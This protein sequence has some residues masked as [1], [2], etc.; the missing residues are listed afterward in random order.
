MFGR[1]VPTRV[2]VRVACW[3]AA[4]SVSCGADP[5]ATLPL[6]D[7]AAASLAGT[8]G[9]PTGGAPAAGVGGAPSPLGTPRCQPPVG[10]NGSPQTI[11]AAVSLLN[12]L[13][14]PTS[15]ACFVQSLDR[16][17]TV[18]AANSPISAQP[19]RSARSPRVFIKLERLWVSVVVDG[20]SSYLLEF[21]HLEPDGL[22]S[23]KGEVLTPLTEPLALSAPYDRIHYAG[24]TVCGVCHSNEQP[25]LDTSLSG[26]FAS[27]PYRPRPETRVA[28]DALL[29]ERQLCDWSIEPHRCEML[30]ALFD[31]GATEEQP[32]PDTMETFY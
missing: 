5:G 16:P 1:H 30:S 12:A 26:A 14:K 6:G 24:G 13:P 11:E 32:F 31:G 22:R 8:A 25:A 27:T 2:T 7:P 19:A 23:V 29:T 4:L 28:W 18:Y 20:D 21:S 9:S 17:L 10:M 15:A 3:L